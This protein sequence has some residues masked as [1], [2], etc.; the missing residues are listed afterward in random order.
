MVSPYEQD[1]KKLDAMCKKIGIQLT[2][3]QLRKR[4]AY[5]KKALPAHLWGK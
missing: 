2:K 3:A 1:I 5:L 4:E